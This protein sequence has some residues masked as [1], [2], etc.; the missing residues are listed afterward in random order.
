M[1]RWIYRSVVV[2]AGAWLMAWGTGC[3]DEP[4]V[5]NAPALGQDVP[6]PPQPAG[7]DAKLVAENDAGTAQAAEG[8][9]A[10]EQKAEEAKGDQAAAG[11]ENAP[12]PGPG[13]GNPM[14]APESV[15]L[16]P[17]PPTILTQDEVKKGDAVTFKGMLSGESCKGHKIRLEALTMDQGQPT[18]ITMKMKEGTGPYELLVPKSDNKLWLTATCDINDN[19]TI[20]PDM[21]WVGAYAQNPIKATGDKK[22]LAIKL[23]KPTKTPPKGFPPARQEPPK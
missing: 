13:P 23:Q 3:P 8:A 10:G 14:A 12:G 6:P 9:A 1:S 20:D 18:V 5:E 17:F 22:G 16:T 21:D 11:S 19:N 7:G 4:V 15:P 2:L